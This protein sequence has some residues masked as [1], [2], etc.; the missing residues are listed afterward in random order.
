MPG[1]VSRA[2]LLVEMR[3]HRGHETWPSGEVSDPLV[4]GSDQRRR[5]GY[6]RTWVRLPFSGE[7][8]QTMTA[9]TCARSTV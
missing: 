9:P 5:T 3:K 1:V 7:S 2:G 8:V 4:S 6:S